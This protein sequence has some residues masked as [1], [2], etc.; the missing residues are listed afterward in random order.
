MPAILRNGIL[1]H[2]L[3]YVS[4]QYFSPKCGRCLVFNIAELCVI[5][6]KDFLNIRTV[7]SYDFLLMWLFIQRE[8][9]SFVI[10]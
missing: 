8:F 4:K 2:R 10:E 9:F 7:K 6:K 5:G 1:Q 3:S